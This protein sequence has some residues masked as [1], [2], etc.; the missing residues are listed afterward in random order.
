MAL[1]LHRAAARSAS[2]QSGRV[3]RPVQRRRRMRIAAELP[4]LL[5]SLSLCACAS[6]SGVSP[7]VIPTLDSLPRDQQER[8]ER[9]DSA[10][11]RPGPEGGR[12]PL[13]GKLHK[14]ET[15]AAT[16]ASLIGFLL[17]GSQTVAIGAGTAFDE[18]LLL[19]PAHRERERH[20]KA[21]EKDGDDEEEADPAYDPA[22]LTPWIDFDRRRGPE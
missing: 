6:G 20:R 8:G 10:A 4:P 22:S 15:A 13:E 11:A 12:R 2:A 14:I 3:A 21:S 18:N 9:L 1:A 17:S 19:D 5:L 7:A 16:A